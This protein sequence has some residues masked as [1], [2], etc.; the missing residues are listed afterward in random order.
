[1]K[2]I[3]V[4]GTSLSAAVPAMGFAMIADQALGRDSNLI[5]APAS[6]VLTAGHDRMARTDAFTTWPPIKAA[7]FQYLPPTGVYR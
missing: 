5:A 3:P 6:A 4:P 7:G 2:L 1:M